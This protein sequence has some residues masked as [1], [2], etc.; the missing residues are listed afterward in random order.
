MLVRL[1]YRVVRVKRHSIGIIL[2]RA[3]EVRHHAIEIVDSLCRRVVRARKQDSARSEEWLNVIRDVA[4]SIPDERRDFGFPTKPR[5]TG[6][7][8]LRSS[9]FRWHLLYT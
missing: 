5:L 3:P 7:G 4:E 1:V 8:T 2:K 9:P 6:T